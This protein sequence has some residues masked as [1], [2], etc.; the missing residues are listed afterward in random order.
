MTDR[1]V[2][3]MGQTFAMHLAE[4]VG[5]VVNEATNDKRGWD[6]LYELPRPHVHAITKIPLDRRPGRLSVRVQVKAGDNIKAPKTGQA[7]GAIRDIKLSNWEELVKSPLPAF[8]LIFDYCDSNRPQHAFLIHVGRELI[9]KTLKRLRQESIKDPNA[10]LNEKYMQI[11]WTEAERISPIDGVSLIAAIENHV[12]FEPEK[13]VREKLKLL[14]EIGYESGEKYDVRIEFPTSEEGGVTAADLADFA[15]GVRSHLDIR[16]VTI[17]DNR[18][19]IPTEEEILGIGR[20]S[21][22]E[23]PHTVA[24]IAARLRDTSG[25]NLVDSTCNLLD[26]TI[27][28]PWLPDIA[29]KLRITSDIFDIILHTNRTVTFSIRAPKHNETETSLEDAAK[30]ARAVR[31]AENASKSG[32]V[33]ELTHGDKKETIFNFDPPTIP[34]ELLEVIEPIINTSEAAEMLGFDSKTK[35]R[36]GGL[37]AQAASISRLHW[38][39]RCANATCDAKMRVTHAEETL[40]AGEKLGVPMNAIVRVSN[41]HVFYAIGVLWGTL[42]V[43]LDTHEADLDNPGIY[44]K[45]SGILRVDADSQAIL[46]KIARS[47][48]QWMIE[49]GIV[50]MSP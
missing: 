45:A 5:I 33:L 8:Y 43:I 25:T 35:V 38:M 47:A 22:H 24:Q 16:T 14:A 7:I 39:L 2:G 23:P 42:G 9:E 19:H 12:G 21:L 48:K 6:L 18:F 17:S 40:K 10:K 31:I 44:I 28:F 32:A 37:P 27:M 36:I 41:E 4:E 15:V 46:A 26:S 3:K 34:R 49:Q 11:T 1:D 29:R 30:F 50:D 20:I 13:Y